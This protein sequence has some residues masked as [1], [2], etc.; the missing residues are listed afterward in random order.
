MLKK[1]QIKKEEVLKI[2]EMTTEELKEK[3]EQIFSL[4]P[5]ELKFFINECWFKNKP[6]KWLKKLY[7]NTINNI[8]SLSLITNPSSYGMGGK[9]EQIKK[10]M[11]LKKALKNEITIK[12]DSEESHIVLW[13]KLSI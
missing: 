4:V 9:K 8:L 3:T 6:E 11:R 2:N 7:N 10:L 5:E 13:Y 12:I 1:K